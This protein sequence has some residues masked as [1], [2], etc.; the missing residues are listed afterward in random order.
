VPR[1][2]KATNLAL[3]RGIPVILTQRGI[4]FSQAMM[5][6]ARML[7]TQEQPVAAPAGKTAPASAP[8]TIQ[9][10]DK[11]KKRFVLFGRSG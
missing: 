3:T 5:G 2:D 6:L 8:Q 11:A 7:R 9:T 1:D 10:T 4:P